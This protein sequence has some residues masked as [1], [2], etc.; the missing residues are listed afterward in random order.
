MRVRLLSIPRNAS[1]SR[2]YACLP[3]PVLHALASMSVWLCLSI[4]V[5]PLLDVIQV[6]GVNWRRS[7]ES[8]HE[9]SSVGGMSTKSSSTSALVRALAILNEVRLYPWP[10]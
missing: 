2:Q 3:V 6:V 4:A 10:H 9:R 8:F 5:F 7:A 1:L